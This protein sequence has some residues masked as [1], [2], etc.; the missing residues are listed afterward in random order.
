VIQNI[1]EIFAATGCLASLYLAQTHKEESKV[2]NAVV[3]SVI[4]T[5][6]TT[7]FYLNQ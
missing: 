4:I 3:T 6:I 5:L 1:P 7:A 2:K